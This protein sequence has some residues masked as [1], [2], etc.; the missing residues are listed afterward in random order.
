MPRWLSSKTFNWKIH[1]LFEHMERKH[2]FIYI[3]FL[4][5]SVFLHKICNQD[6]DKYTLY[7]QLPTL[8]RPCSGRFQFIF[9][10][11]IKKVIIK[12]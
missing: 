2:H 7:V 12:K 5:Y 11:D 4:Q 10:I 6:K 3:L 1:S 9:Y 8:L